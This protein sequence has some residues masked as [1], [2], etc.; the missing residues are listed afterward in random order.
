M[1]I[2]HYKVTTEVTE[3][4]LDNETYDLIPVQV[5]KT[6]SIPY[7]LESNGT[8]SLKNND[9][10]YE[11]TTVGKW[12]WNMTTLATDGLEEVN[13]LYYFNLTITSDGNEEYFTDPPAFIRCS[14]SLYISSCGVTVNF[15]LFTLL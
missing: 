6:T 1:T 13:P 15:I 7:Y 9:W 14:K 3:F 12:V 10:S 5:N 4:I 2:V 8:W 11:N